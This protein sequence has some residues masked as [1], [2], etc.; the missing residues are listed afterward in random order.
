MFDCVYQTQFPVSPISRVVFLTSI[1][2]CSQWWNLSYRSPLQHCNLKTEAG[3]YRV[4]L[5]V[6]VYTDTLSHSCV[7]APLFILSSR[8]HTKALCVYREIE[9]R[10]AWVLSS[11]LPSIWECMAMVSHS[12]A[13]CWFVCVCGSMVP[14]ILKWCWFWRRGI[15]RLRDGGS[16][17]LILETNDAVTLIGLTDVILIILMCVC[18]CACVSLS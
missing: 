1:R 14:F 4:A 9:E 2:L 15:S 11:S 8:G 12:T 13:V 10:Q 7:P 16:F 18:V 6:V 17:P 5:S 3:R